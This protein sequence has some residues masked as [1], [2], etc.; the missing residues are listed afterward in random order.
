MHPGIIKK[1]PFMKKGESFIRLIGLY[2]NILRHDQHFTFMNCGDNNKKL[3]VRQ[4][5]N[6]LSPGSAFTIYIIFANYPVR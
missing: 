6:G 2:S 5:I 4:P 3:L 1:N